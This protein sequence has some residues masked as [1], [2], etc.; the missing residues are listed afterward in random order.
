MTIGIVYFLYGRMLGPRF[1]H[2]LRV[3]RW[4]TLIFA[5]FPSQILYTS[6]ISDSILFQFLLCLGVLILLNCDWRMAMV[7]GLVFGLAALTRPYVLF[8]PA[9][10]IAYN[11]PN[12][13][14]KRT[15]SHLA[16]AFVSMLTVIMP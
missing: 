9:V 13:S 3:Q 7:G 14:I 15:L 1:S 12:Q 8:V 10:A 4:S 16:L 11:R 5:F 6:L 2:R